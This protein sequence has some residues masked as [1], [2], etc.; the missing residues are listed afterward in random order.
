[1]K[2][3]LKPASIK[4]YRAKCQFCDCEFE[5]NRGDAID[6]MDLKKTLLGIQRYVTCPECGA[7]IPHNSD[8]PRTETIMT[9]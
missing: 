9:C 7:F 5:Y 1:M 3:I 2:R 4:V 8:T 6:L